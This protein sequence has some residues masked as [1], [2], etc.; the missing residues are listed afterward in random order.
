M[1]I[2]VKEL[3]MEGDNLS[4][5]EISK[6]APLSNESMKILE[7]LLDPLRHSE[8]IKTRNGFYEHI[9]RLA[10]IPMDKFYREKI[11]DL[12][13]KII[14]AG[15]IPKSFVEP[16]KPGKT[17]K[18]QMNFVNSYILAQEMMIVNSKE[19]NIQKFQVR[20]LHQ[21]CLRGQTTINEA[22]DKRRQLA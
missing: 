6:D 13:K 14:Q 19:E 18:A 21:D 17:A 12:W 22:D 2:Q 8:V 1:E 20:K 7:D 10:N 4:V 16:P 11:N 15:K 5:L 3:T 9:A